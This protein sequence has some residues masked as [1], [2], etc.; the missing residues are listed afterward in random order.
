MT[1]RAT[2]AGLVLA[3]AV[4]A[5]AEQ[6][7]PA[8]DPAP[9]PAQASEVAEA[10][11]SLGTDPYVVR[12][13]LVGA[14]RDAGAVRVTV[15]GRPSETTL[16]LVYEP[17]R[18]R[19]ARRFGWHAGGDPQ[20]LLELGTGRVCANL[21]AARA[22]QAS[23]NTAMGYV[24][25][26]DRP[27]SCTAGGDSGLAAFVVYGYSALDPVTRLARL[28]GP[29]T[30]TDLGIETA[31][32]GAATRHLRMEASESD[33]SLRQLPTSYDLWVDSDLRLV[34]AVFS[35]LDEAV[36]A[37]D[38]SFAYGELPGVSLPARADRG[39]LVLHTGV[40]PG[41]VHPSPAVGSGPG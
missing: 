22:L 1:A 23:G 15:T 36:E 16:D 13:T 40:G 7:D 33:R 26:S 37:Y 20:E 24:E 2:V 25:A 29:V 10:P 4:S 14:V 12:D 3:T 35:S 38:A 8:A 6:A 30:V 17:D 34:R 19:F 9:V 5:C 27:Y 21:A 18:E 39:D 28:M 41:T 32:G 11:A 31:E